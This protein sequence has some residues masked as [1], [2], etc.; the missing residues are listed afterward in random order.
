MS[1]HLHTYCGPILVIQAPCDAVH[2]LFTDEMY[3]RLSV[4]SLESGPKDT[5]YLLPNTLG[6]R[7]FSWAERDDD[8][9]TA[10]HPAEEVAWFEKE[11]AEEIAFFKEDF[12]VVSVQFGV[13]RSYR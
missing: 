4:Q 1:S 5:A 2:A 6:P 12:G 13:V 10:V 7:E 8:G 11:F 9:F 3:D